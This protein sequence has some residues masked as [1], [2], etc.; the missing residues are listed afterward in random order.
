M[1]ELDN[2]FKLGQ[3]FKLGPVRKGSDFR[4]GMLVPSPQSIENLT[5]ITKR[6]REMASESER[7]VA[8]EAASLFEGCLITILQR[9][10]D[11]PRLANSIREFAGQFLRV[12]NIGSTPD[13]NNDMPNGAQEDLTNMF[14]RFQKELA[15]VVEKH[16]Q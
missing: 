2:E 11:N 9:S 13:F 7:R 1:S 6:K 16:K 8:S 3:A 12:M 10:K 14:A 15:D 4:A 5:M